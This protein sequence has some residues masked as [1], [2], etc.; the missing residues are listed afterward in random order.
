MPSR[1]F[2][3]R[4]RRSLRRQARPVFEKVVTHTAFTSILDDSVSPPA[5]G[6]IAS[7]K[8]VLP[9]ARTTTTPGI[10]YGRVYFFKFNLNDAISTALNPDSIRNLLELYREY[11][12]SRIKVG[13]YPQPTSSWSMSG[14]VDVAT[15]Q[16]LLNSTVS[17][18]GPGSYATT[19]VYD[20]DVPFLASQQDS[21]GDWANYFAGAAGARKHRLDKPIVRYFQPKQALATQS[22]G[23]ALLSSVYVKPRWNSTQLTGATGT[24]KWEQYSGLLIAFP[25]P[26]AVV[27]NYRVE[28]TYYIQYRKR[29]L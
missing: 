9:S 15:T 7:Q 3:R 5:W 22:S 25:G 16:A 29:G 1:A 11:K 2:S 20:T 19:I 13:L 27:I 12:V 17:P 21:G 10:D 6:T 23:S 24:S 14:A 18:A 4:R 8:F 28:I 26:S